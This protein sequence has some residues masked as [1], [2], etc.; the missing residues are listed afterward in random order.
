MSSIKLV[1]A[2]WRERYPARVF[3]PFAILITAAGIA[4]GGS[5]PSV[6]DAIKGF[7][8]SYTLVL[9][10]RIGDDVADLPRDLVHTPGRVLVRASSRTPII[11]LALLVASGAVLTMLSQPWPGARIA[12]FATMTPLLGVWYHA[13]GRLRGGPLIGAHVLLLKYPAIALL[14]CARWDSLTLYS[15]LPTLGAIYLGLCIYEQVHDRAVRESR[16]APWVFAAEIVLLGGLPLLAIS[17][18]G[19]LP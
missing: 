3:V 8:L 11:V 12:L 7:F 9:A 15:A 1:Y 10:F 14:A 18:G 4:A 19:R 16:G 2:Y 6:R 13:R 5:L 17:A